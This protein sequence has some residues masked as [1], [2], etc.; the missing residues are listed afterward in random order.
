LPTTFPT[1]L[2]TKPRQFERRPCRSAAHDFELGLFDAISVD[3]LGVSFDDVFHVNVSTQ[4]QPWT[5]SS[6]LPITEHDKVL[7]IRDGVGSK[8]DYEKLLN[9]K[10]DLFILLG[11]GVVV[12]VA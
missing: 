12:E 2:Q 3:C 6:I 1:N 11:K 7:D 9:H 8:Q 4:S 10:A 5:G